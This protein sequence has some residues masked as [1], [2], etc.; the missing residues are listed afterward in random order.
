LG[1]ESIIEG[2]KDSSSRYH[3]DKV[4]LSSIMSVRSIDSDAEPGSQ[5]SLRSRPGKKGSPYRSTRF[6]GQFF[7]ISEDDLHNH[8]DMNNGSNEIDINELRNNFRRKGSSNMDT[9]ISIENDG[10]FVK[11]GDNNNANSDDIFSY[12]KLSRSFSRIDSKSWTDVGANIAKSKVDEVV[13]L[14]TICVD[15][16]KGVEVEELKKVKSTIDRFPS[17]YTLSRWTLIELWELWDCNGDLDNNDDSMGTFNNVVTTSDSVNNISE[18][19]INDKETNYLTTF[20][21]RFK[22]YAKRTIIIILSFTFFGHLSTPSGRSTYLVIFWKAFIMMKVCLGVWNDDCMQAFDADKSFSE[23]VL[24]DTDEKNMGDTLEAVVGIRSVLFQLIPGLTLLSV[25]VQ[26]TSRSP[27]YISNKVLL[28]SVPSFLLSFSQARELAI[29]TELRR[30][31]EHHSQVEKYKEYNIQE[32]TIAMLTLNIF[33]TKSRLVDY[34]IGA[35]SVAMSISVVFGT[36]ATNLDTASTAL[37]IKTILIV[38]LVIYVPYSFFLALQYLVIFGKILHL[39]DSDFWFDFK[40]V[41]VWIKDSCCKSNTADLI[42]LSWIVLKTDQENPELD[43]N[44]NIA[45]YEEEPTYEPVGDKPDESED[46]DND[47]VDSNDDKA[48]VNEPAPLNSASQNSDLDIGS[49]GNEQDLT[50]EV[51]CD[52][53]NSLKVHDAI[54]SNEE[55]IFPDVNSE[56]SVDDIVQ[57]DTR[58]DLT[59]IDRFIDKNS[60]RKRYGSVTIDDMENII[61]D[62]NNDDDSNYIIKE[63]SVYNEETAQEQIEIPDVNN[64]ILS[65]KQFGTIVDFND[66]ENLDEV[67]DNDSTNV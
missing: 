5:K 38:L 21:N 48:D 49:E 52:Q 15:E 53:N 23:M 27:I 64:N 9:R 47:E 42:K 13:V 19:S 56:N 28:E 34:C 44:D 51:G 50:F 7:S 4:V 31:G 36:A 40:S 2:L 1:L 18:E 24:G 54:N 61:I 6:K 39:R 17:Y 62:D 12:G 10:G 63:E 57:L 37:F 8:D 60:S 45:D 58:N 59:V 55:S 11:I 14:T 66:I 35:L 41:W 46:D 65:G 32:W 20:L 25:Y 33:V 3:A 16:L 26:N 22:L 43:I 30:I 29:E 67:N